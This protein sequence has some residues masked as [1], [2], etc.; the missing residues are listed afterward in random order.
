MCPYIA[1]TIANDG[2]QDATILVYLFILNQLY[3]FRA[4]SSSIIRST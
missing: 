2:Q 1:S 4:I 3:M